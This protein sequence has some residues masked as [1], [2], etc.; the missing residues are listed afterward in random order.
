[1][2]T[3]PSGKFPQKQSRDGDR[4]CGEADASKDGAA[5]LG[6]HS[7]A[8]GHRGGV[9]HTQRHVNLA[10]GGGFQSNHVSITGAGTV[11][12]S[13]HGIGEH[14]SQKNA[15]VQSIINKNRQVA[16]KWIPLGAC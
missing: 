5:L 14:T 10:D 7:Q 8:T 6:Q 4:Q 2:S 15:E 9:S 1:M 3:D 13:D 16:P 12:Q 11:G